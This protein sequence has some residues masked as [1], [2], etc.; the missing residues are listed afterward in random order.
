MN[1]NIS[2][3]I[4]II[5]KHS[6]L[7]CRNK[8][9][10]LVARN[11]FEFFFQLEKD[12]II[13]ENLKRYRRNIEQL[14]NGKNVSDEVKSLIE[15][16]F[17]S[18][19]DRFYSYLEGTFISYIFQG[20]TED[21]KTVD[22][23]KD[24]HRVI[25]ACSNVSI[26]DKEAI[27]KIFGEKKY[28]DFLGYSFY[29]SLFQNNQFMTKN[30]YSD[31]KKIK[32]LKD[33][34]IKLLCHAVED[35]TYKKMIKA[36]FNNIS[37]K[38]GKY[39]VPN[40]LF[41]KRTSRENR[42]LIPFKDV[43]NS[44][45]TYEQL[46]KFQGG[47]TVE[48]INNEYFEQL[49]LP[50]NEQNEVFKILKDKLGSDDNVSAM[51]D[52]KNDRNSSSS[53]QRK[54]LESLKEYLDQ[55][56][57]QIGEEILIKRK[58]DVK[59]SGKGNDKWEGYVYY[60]IS[61]GQ[62]DTK[63]SH[64]EYKISAEKVQLFNPA[65]EYAGE[66]VSLDITLVLIYFALFSI[67]DD[68]RNQVWVAYINECLSYFETRSYKTPEGTRVALYDYVNN[69]VSLKIKKGELFDPIQV[70]KI[71][72]E[73]FALNTRSD[74]SLDITHQSS[75]NNAQYIYDEELTDGSVEGVLLTPANPINLFWSKHLSNMMQQN[76]SLKDYF[77]EQRENV[78]KWDEL[79]I[80][81]LL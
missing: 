12:L 18:D 72:I 22:I 68:M 48:F 25:T 64:K 20:N 76:F 28:Y 78:E 49:S 44:N 38:T 54:A 46:G 39:G 36:K 16:N 79:G 35:E 3:Y 34:G 81:D 5:I 77:K 73:D 2:S 66:N 58:D 13:E 30:D 24:I 9:P 19:Y 41:Q 62:Q 10:N 31:L 47:V 57:Q 65:I 4:N 67:K 50:T 52:I 55:H 11:L 21:E 70:K 8:T 43:Q 1:F 6:T 56:D 27:Q 75:V 63:D 53:S 51:I 74:D 23:C 40:T 32:N 29:I 15:E 80:D 33:E 37:G 7:P 71:T 26:E 45:I 61:G 69:H 17:Q 14:K 60:D 42:V 59:Y